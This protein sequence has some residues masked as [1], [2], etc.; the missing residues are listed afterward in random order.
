MKPP[1]YTAKTSKKY[2]KPLYYNIKLSILTTEKKETS[3][4]GTLNE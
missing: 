4:F 1:P 3:L 2:F